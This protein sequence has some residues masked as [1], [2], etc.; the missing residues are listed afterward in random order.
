[1]AELPLPS[2]SIQT[3]IAAILSAYD[4]LIENNQRRIVLLE[5]L[6]EEIYREWFVR[7]RF[8]GHEKV[9]KIKG[10]PEGWSLKRF[11]EIVEHYSGG[12][13]GE[14]DRSPSFS[15][16]AFVI[17]G[18]DIPDVQ[19]GEFDRCPFRFHK[20]SN[21]KSRTL[22][23]NDFVFEV[24]GGSKDQLLGRNVLV[25][26]RVLKF[27][28]SPV[29]AASFCKQIRFRQDMV[30][31][32]FMKYFMKLY[33]DCD[34]VG[35][36]QVQSTGI[37]N[38]QFESFLKFQTIIIP[39]DALQKQFEEKVKPLIDMRDDVAL[40]SIALRKTPRPPSPAPDLRQTLRR[41]ARHPVPARHGGGII[42]LN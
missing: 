2:L 10:V 12:G 26:E 13:W 1:M 22:Q 3:K 19:A 39:P 40:A 35:I 6:A 20:P 24:S 15:D 38:Y 29:M 32:Y 41:K 4:E 28:N 5:K 16:G 7:L 27:F 36:Y 25:T 14:D 21:L 8:P 33:Y 30:S 9:K 31:P 42:G 17:R 11:H 37:S 18:T 34:A 23:S